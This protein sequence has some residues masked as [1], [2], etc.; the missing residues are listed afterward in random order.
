MRMNNSSR[1]LVFRT[2]VRVVS[3]ES[4]EEH[5]KRFIKFFSSPNYELQ[6]VDFSRLYAY[7]SRRLDV[8]TVALLN[9]DK[10]EKEINYSHCV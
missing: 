6:I 8:S 9:V 4:P 2:S 10:R 1:S 3:G 7:M 5:D